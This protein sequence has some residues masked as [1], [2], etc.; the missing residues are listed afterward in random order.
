MSFQAAAETL[1]GSVKDLV[2]SLPADEGSLR[3]KT[4]KDQT[5]VVEWIQKV[6][7]G[8]IAK[9]ENIKVSIHMYHSTHWWN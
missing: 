7:Q 8:D 3:G 5:E 1:N 6:G 2:N 9:E 4:E